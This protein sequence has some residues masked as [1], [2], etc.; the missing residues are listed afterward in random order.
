MSI[1]IDFANN[2][3]VFTGE[4]SDTEFARIFGFPAQT[5]RDAA[6]LALRGAR[7][8]DDMHSQLSAA[9]SR[10]YHHFVEQIR[11][12]LDTF[13]DWSANREDDN[14]TSPRAHR[15][16]GLALAFAQGTTAT[17]R[18]SGSPRLKKPLGTFTLLELQQNTNHVPQQL[19]FGELS[20]AVEERPQTLWLLLFHRDA[21]N[22]AVRLEVSLPTGVS[23]DG[24]ILG[25]DKR[26]VLGE[27]GMNNQIM[28]VRDDE[29]NEDDDAAVAISAR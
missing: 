19:E 25:W 1:Q 15:S 24:K 22:E 29:R 4:S 5:L 18:I 16:D 17:G 23:D 7:E 27:I 8:T 26:I 21:D 28:E 10:F 14:H 9:G 13:D 3:R 11:A 12:E 6:L 20:E 2:S